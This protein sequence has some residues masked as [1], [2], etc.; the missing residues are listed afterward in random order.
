MLKTI[1]VSGCTKGIGLSIVKKFASHG[2]NVAGCA[3]NSKE[4]SALL[5]ELSTTY[6][7]QKF[8]FRVCDVAEKELL[9]IFASEVIREFGTIEVLVNNA[10]EFIP[11]T[12]ENEAEGVF[13]KLM[14]VN[15]SSTYHLTRAVLPV[16][17]KNK[18][19]HIFN[20]CS[21]A[22]I[23][24]Y[25]NGGSYCISKY[26]MMGLN[27]VLREELKNKNIKVTAL[28]P[29]ATLT[30]SWAGTS[31]PED[32]FIP[33]DDIAKLVWAAFDLSDSSNVE[34]ILIRPTEGDI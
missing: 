11:G 21:T 1:L 20:I 6:L 16:M 29:G 13:E 18:K 5:N 8:F 34:E 30:N 27:Q 31:L 33:A 14:Q 7:T 26:A 3:R 25:T 2:F 15:V 28:L 32:R 10:G 12:I 24:P 17:Q 22:S 4:L 23:T 19:G 9:K